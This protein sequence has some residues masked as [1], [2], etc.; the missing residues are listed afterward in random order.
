MFTDIATLLSDARARLQSWR[1]DTRTLLL[2]VGDAM[3][4]C[5]FAAIGHKTHQEATGLAALGQ[6]A[7]TAV[8]FALG[9]FAVAPFLGAFRRSQTERPAQ[10]LPWTELAWLAAWPLALLLRWALSADHQVPPSFALVILLAN[11]LLLGA[12]RTVF[13][14][15]ATRLPR[16]R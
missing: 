6:I 7:W 4:F 16:V 5:L 2:V 3:A 14:L 1:P 12:W 15:V 11:A 10:M 13:A 8:P 9:W